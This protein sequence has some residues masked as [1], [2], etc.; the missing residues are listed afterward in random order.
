MKESRPLPRTS[1][2]KTTIADICTEEES[3]GE[4]GRAELGVER[5]EKE[6]HHSLS[7]KRPFTR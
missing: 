3:A 5:E 6:G 1:I 7:E 4:E 2:R